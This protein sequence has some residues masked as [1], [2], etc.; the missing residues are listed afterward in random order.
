MI[1]PNDRQARMR[2]ANPQQGRKARAISAVTDPEADRRYEMVR[3]YVEAAASWLT[4]LA[5]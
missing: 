2:I 4:C 1:W 5:R 3:R